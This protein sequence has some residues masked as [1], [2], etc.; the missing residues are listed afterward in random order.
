MKKIK[1]IKY[2]SNI[3]YDNTI[4]AV[5]V[6]AF[7]TFFMNIYS[8]EIGT[9]LLSY[10]N[11]IFIIVILL[12]FYFLKNNI[13]QSNSTQTT[14][15]N[16]ILEADAYIGRRVSEA[17][18]LKIIHFSSFGLY[19][20]KEQPEYRKQLHL[21]L[22][23]GGKFTRMICKNDDKSFYKWILSDIQENKKMNFNLFYLNK[24][25]LSSIRILGLLIIDDEEVFLGSPYL[26]SFKYP[27]MAFREKELV[28]FYIDYFYYF[29][30]KSYII[31]SENHTDKK[32]IKEFMEDFEKS[33]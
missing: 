32:N 30:S 13:S 12:E 23:R 10:L 11:P 1:L 33:K 2:L 15:F 3:Y 5:I 9:S 18:N 17:K 7:I 20:E 19:S 4:F 8:S 24:I 25:K 27:I 14:V 26:P 28:K 6:I 31:F 29:K 21:F 16:S 22:Q